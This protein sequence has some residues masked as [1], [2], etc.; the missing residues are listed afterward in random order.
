[1]GFN[2]SQ[3]VSVTGGPVSSVSAVFSSAVSTGQHLIAV[4]AFFN[5][6]AVTFSTITDNVNNAGF[7]AR[8]NSTLVGSTADH[9]RI[10][11]KLNLSS[12][13]AASTY[14]LSANYSGNVGVSLCGLIYEKSGIGNSSFGS[15]GS[16]NGTSTGPR[17][18]S[19]TASTSPCL[20]VS[21]AT[22]SAVNAFVSTASASATWI[23]T[24]DNPNANQ[25]LNVIHSTNAT[26]TQQPTHSLN[27]SIGWVAGTVVYVGSQDG[28]G[29]G[30]IG[31][32]WHMCMM[33]VQ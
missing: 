20:F 32:M 17:G 25:P 3:F 31:R 6:G 18:P 13:A 23:T 22:V 19:M 29:G 14:R 27:A 10:H 15:T 8:I 7:V 4:Q 26:L 12:G 2:L 1:M 9:V 30:A 28:G 33:G 5:T 24:I 11:D 16:S 21:G